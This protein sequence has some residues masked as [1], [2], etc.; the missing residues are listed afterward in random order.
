[1]KSAARSFTHAP[2]LVANFTLSQLPENRAGVATAWDNVLYDSPALGYVVA[3]HQQMRLRPGATVL[4]YYHALSAMTPQ[5]GRAALQATPREVWVEQILADLERA[6][7]D[8]RKVTTRLDVFR[9]GH[10]MVRPLPGLIRGE[11]RRLLAA[12]RPCLRFAHADVSG[13]SLFEEAQ[14]RGVLA[15]E[16]TLWRLGKQFTTSLG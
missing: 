4:T 7:P 8:I 6:H 11:A 15:A 12:D 13:F 2:W 10:A 1:M 5:A 9:D 3:T 16:R 14:Y